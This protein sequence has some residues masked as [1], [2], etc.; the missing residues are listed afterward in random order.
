[1]KTGGEILKTA[2]ISAEIAGGAETLENGSALL[3]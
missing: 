2:R 3:I 1:M